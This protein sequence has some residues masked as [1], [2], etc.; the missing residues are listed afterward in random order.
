MG[1]SVAG[2]RTAQALRREGFAGRV[3]LVG[4]EDELPYDKPPLSKQ[5]LGGTLDASRLR[6]LTEESAASA[7][8]ELRLGAAATSLDVPGH[9]V[10]LA[11][12]TEIGYGACV[13]ATGASAR[14][15]PW[16]ARSGVHLLRT[17]A[18]SDHLRSSLQPGRSVVVVGGGF[19][20]AEVAAGA[21]AQGCRVTVVDP[22]AAPAARVV[23]D[24]VGEL[25]ASVHG[26]H[27]VS[28]RF[29]LG[30]SSLQGQE[31][32]VEVGLT[33]GSRLVADAAVVGIGATPNDQWLAGSGLSLDDGVLCDELCRAVDGPDVFCAGDVA[34]WLHPR[35]GEPVRVEHWTNAGEQ[36]ACVGHNIAHPG[37]LRAHRPVEYVWSDQYDWRVQ[38]VGRPRRG[39]VGELVGD[40]DGTPPK[41]AALFAAEGGRLEGAVTVNWPRA[42]VDC[43]RLV[44]ESATYE[45]A[46]RVLAQASVAPSR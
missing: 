5:Y 45:E 25:L 2:V 4:E 15:F 40:P 34:R 7:G 37:D 24:E 43:R 1:A 44:G 41:W 16:A 21:A 6:L 13:I 20:G 10:H 29:G 38:I 19:I 31:G 35:Y 12:G 32:R 8:V 28:T 46:L 14:S 33:D 11:D 18:D 9:R 23:G 30:V 39:V 3:V 26:R 42:S 22:L 27:G 17:R 36:A